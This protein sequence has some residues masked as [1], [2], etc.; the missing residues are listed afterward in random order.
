VRTVPKNAAPINPTLE[1]T[2]MRIELWN[3]SDIKPYEN[4]LRLF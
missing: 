1:N 3:L 4:N 2:V